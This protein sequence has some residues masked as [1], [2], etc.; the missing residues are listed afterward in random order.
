MRR[1]LSGW[2]APFL[3]WCHESTTDGRTGLALPPPPT[4]EGG[5][6][7]CGSV[8]SH[9]PGEDARIR[10]RKRPLV[11]QPRQKQRA[12]ALEE[13]LPDRL[14]QLLAIGSEE[15]APHPFD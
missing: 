8:G 12:V 3:T 7:S 14:G 13:L 15:R 10:V 6:A 2:A 11:R 5:N 9:P 4:L 1:A